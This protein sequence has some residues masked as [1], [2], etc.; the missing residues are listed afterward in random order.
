[1]VPTTRIIQSFD[2]DFDLPDWCPVEADSLGSLNILN[3][4]Q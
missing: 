3:H 1:M 4:D 2:F